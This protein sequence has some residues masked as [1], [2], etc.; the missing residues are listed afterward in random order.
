MPSVF[1]GEQVSFHALMEIRVSAALRG[2]AQ[3][4]RKVVGSHP[5]VQKRHVEPSVSKLAA[6]AFRNHDGQ[7]HES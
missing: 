5:S 2:E 7:H 6:E 3:I 4:E 1:E